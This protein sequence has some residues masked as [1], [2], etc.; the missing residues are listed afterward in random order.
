MGNQ[1]KRV[2]I[3]LETLDTATTAT[4]VSIGA[5]RFNMDGVNNFDTFYRAVNWSADKSRSISRDTLAWWLAQPA[6]VQAALKDERA[7]PLAVALVEFRY[8][9]GADAEVWAGPANFDLSILQNA[10]EQYQLE[11]PWEFFNTRCYTTLRRLSPNIPRVASD[12]PHNALEDAKAQAQHAAQLLRAM[13]PL[14]TPS[15]LGL[16]ASKAGGAA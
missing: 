15:A 12:V 3:D 7:I 6:E 10:Y 1:V 2:M 9:L 8:W 16:S 11:T 14:E 4:I 5:V 13:V